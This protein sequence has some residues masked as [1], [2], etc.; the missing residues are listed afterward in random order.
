MS[1]I[2]FRFLTAVCDRMTAG[3]A[4]DL[5]SLFYQSFGGLRIR[6]ENHI[7][8]AF[9]QLRIDFVIDLEH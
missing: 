5:G 9:K 2:V 7:F 4:D 1:V 6:I 8:D 3:L